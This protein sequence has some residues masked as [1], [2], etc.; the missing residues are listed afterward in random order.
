[1]NLILIDLRNLNHVK[2]K[3]LAKHF[4]WNEDVLFMFKENDIAKIWVDTQTKD[5]VAY[6][7]K[8]NPQIQIGH[9]FSEKLNSMD[10]FS[11]PKKVKSLNLNM[12]SILDKISKFGIK[13]LSI[14]EKEYLD[15]ISK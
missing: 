12:D 1:M 6:T 5:V 3:E 11:L 13:S 15:N 2:L 9:E 14:E 8:K 4:D 7:M 10:V